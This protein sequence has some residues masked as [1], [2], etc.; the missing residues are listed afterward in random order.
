MVR[1]STTH[2]SLLGPFQLFFF[3]FCRATRHASWLAT[4]VTSLTVP[5]IGLARHNTQVSEPWGRS[6]N[7]LHS[8]RRSL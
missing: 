5:N 8:A 4:C 2:P 7:P 1:T 6:A 3:F